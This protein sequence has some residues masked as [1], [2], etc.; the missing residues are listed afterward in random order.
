[1]STLAVNWWALAL[2]GVFAILFGALSLAL[3]G[4]TLRV[5]ATLFGVYAAADGAFAL[6]SGYRAME[7][8]QQWGA[9]A[10]EGAVGIGAGLVSFLAPASS[11]RAF[12]YLI[13]AY[14]VVTG[15]YEVVA[16]VRLRDE[17]EGEWWLATGGALSILFGV[18]I[19]ASPMVGAIAV[20][21]WVAAYAVGFGVVLV[22]LSLRLRTL[23]RTA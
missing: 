18:L 19:A 1:M 5:L 2:R 10:L 6:L 15:I 9:F 12:L 14:A 20:V 16:A 22:G 3:P 23:L 21:R 8:G 7:R 17:I 4:V 11:I 13:G